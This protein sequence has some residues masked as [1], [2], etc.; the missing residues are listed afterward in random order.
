MRENIKAD[1]TTYSEDQAEVG[2]FF[3]EN[4]DHLLTDVMDL[5]I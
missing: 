4:F 5:E 3:L 1:L 2:E